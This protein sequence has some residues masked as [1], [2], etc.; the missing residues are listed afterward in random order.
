LYYIFLIEILVYLVF[1]FI[2]NYAMTVILKRN[3]YIYK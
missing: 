3:K 1:L 2:Y